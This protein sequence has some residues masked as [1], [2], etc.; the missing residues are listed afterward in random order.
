MIMEQILI[1][2]EI[3]RIIKDV[4]KEKVNPNFEMTSTF[5]KYKPNYDLLAKI[6]LK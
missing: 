2:E 1:Y 6:P 3:E 5:D 4:M